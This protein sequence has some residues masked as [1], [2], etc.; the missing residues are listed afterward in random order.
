VDHQSKSFRKKECSA[1][2]RE[3][4]GRLLDTCQFGKSG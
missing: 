4:R 1:G 3:Q 2:S